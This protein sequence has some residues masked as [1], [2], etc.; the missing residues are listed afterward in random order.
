MKSFVKTKFLSWKEFEDHT[1]IIDSRTNKQVH[2]LNEVGS[3]LWKKL[4]T[5]QSAEELVMELTSAYDVTKEDAISDVDLFLSTLKE[6]ALI[7][8]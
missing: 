8:E 5:H 6:K 7:H 3:F 4:D 2:R 1:L